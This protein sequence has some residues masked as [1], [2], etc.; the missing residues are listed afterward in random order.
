M[1]EDALKLI[2]KEINKNESLEDKGINIIKFQFLKKSNLLKVV[3]RG[4]DGLNNQEEDEVK[5]AIKKTLGIDINIEVL[6]YRDISNLTLNEIVEKQIYIYT[7][8][9]H[10]NGEY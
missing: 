2:K 6:F 3:L 9:M 1:S 5:R 7:Y 4:K 8:L 10:K